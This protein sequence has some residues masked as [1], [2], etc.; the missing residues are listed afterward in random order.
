MSTSSD[1]REH[2][3][4]SV[5]WRARIAL[6][7]TSMI[8]ASIINISDGGL[9]FECGTLIPVGSLVKIEFYFSNQKKTDKVRAIIKVTFNTIMAD[10]KGA[11]IGANFVKIGPQYESSFKKII[12]KL[13]DQ[14]EK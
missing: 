11:Q 14:I 9:S 10:N 1:R 3:R 4:H 6:E 5:N 8:N 7:N 2:V 13:V 12:A